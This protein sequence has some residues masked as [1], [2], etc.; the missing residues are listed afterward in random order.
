[1]TNS[2]AILPNAMAGYTWMDNVLKTNEE[3]KAQKEW[4]EMM[5]SGL[6]GKRGNNNT[7]QYN[8]GE[9]ISVGDL[10]T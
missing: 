4:E 7:Q 2:D 8:I 6:F 5:R 1:M 3:N 9:G 10:P